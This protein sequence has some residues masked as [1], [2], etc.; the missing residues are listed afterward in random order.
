MARN[1]GTILK[2]QVGEQMLSIH[3]IGPI[4]QSCGSIMSHIQKCELLYIATTLREKPHNRSKLNKPENGGN[5]RQE[6][7]KSKTFSQG[8]RMFFFSCGRTN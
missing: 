1:W 6:T 7:N 2:P 4:V 8:A 5:E 3:P